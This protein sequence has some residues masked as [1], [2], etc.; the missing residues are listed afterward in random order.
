MH[1]FIHNE[2]CEFM[3]SEDRVISPP[4]CLN[5]DL[6]SDKN[7]T[8]PSYSSKAESSYGIMIFGQSF[9]KSPRVAEEDGDT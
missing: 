2:D 5:G 3:H 8:T 4:W 9:P 6:N 1:S 7:D